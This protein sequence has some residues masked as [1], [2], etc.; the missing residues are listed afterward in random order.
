MAESQAQ[1]EAALTTL[2]MLDSHIVQ[3][4]QNRTSW[5]LILQLV[6][7]VTMT[8]EQMTSELRR[9]LL[10]VW[11]HSDWELPGD[12]GAYAEVLALLN[13]I[14]DMFA[15]MLQKKLSYGETFYLAAMLAGATQG[16]TPLMRQQ[17]LYVL[18][19]KRLVLTDTPVRSLVAA[20]D[21]VQETPSEISESYTFVS[22]E[23]PPLPSEN[24]PE[25]AAPTRPG[26]R[27]S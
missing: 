27:R 7:F 18:E 21:A 13:Q 3:V 26:R 17:M 6:A 2:N 23:E 8:L 10:Y 25:P 22:A 12:P 14:H 1:Y 11:Q 9:A 15:N 24:I 19:H 4:V 5:A 16:M 20:L